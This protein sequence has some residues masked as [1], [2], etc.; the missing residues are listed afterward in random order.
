MAETCSLRL[1]FPLR[2]QG[3]PVQSGSQATCW[4]EVARAELGS[5]LWWREAPALPVSNRRVFVSLPGDRCRRPK[6]REAVAP[7]RRPAPRRPGEPLPVGGRHHAPG[8]RQLPPEAPRG[9]RP[10]APARRP[11]PSPA[12]APVSAAAGRRDD[13]SPEPSSDTS[14]ASPV[15]PSGPSSAASSGRQTPPARRAGSPHPELRPQPRSTCAL[16]G[17]GWPRRRCCAR[18]VTPSSGLP[19]PG[20]E[21]PAPGRPPSSPLSST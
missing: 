2:T 11:G 6:P 18:S 10:G 5:R 16:G 3:P 14:G 20:F 13:A 8:R 21:D 4:A 15:P 1:R 17:G 19:T 7:Q 12:R 9:R